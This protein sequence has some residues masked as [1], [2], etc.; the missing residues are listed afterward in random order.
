M[1][2]DQV[3]EISPFIPNQLAMASSQA[4]APMSRTHQYRKIMKPLLER[5]RRARMNKCLDELKDIMVHN[6]QSEGESI[7]KLEKADVLE[8][9]VKY[10]R[11]LKKENA[12]GLTPQATYA[13]KFKSGY[14]HCAQEVTNF[15]TQSPGVD[16]QVS[17]KLLSHLSTCVQA[18]E[19][20]PPSVLNSTPTTTSTAAAASVLSSPG[21]VVRVPTPMQAPESPESDIDVGEEQ[22]L[23]LSRSV[24]SPRNRQFSNDSDSGNSSLNK[25]SIEDGFDRSWRPW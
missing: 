4:E 6:L 5:K 17:T 16:N 20:I 11:K 2:Y 24:V 21:P 15:I 7:T 25:D 1:M 12:L 13:G 10:L 18:L 23:D 9:T 19:V 3:A 8:L 22:A 14:A